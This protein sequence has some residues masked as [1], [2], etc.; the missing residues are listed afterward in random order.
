MADNFKAQGDWFQASFIWKSIVAHYID[1]PVLVERAQ[2]ALDQMPV[3][4]DE[5][6]NN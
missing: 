3:E 1:F 2:A 6:L 5:P 4:G